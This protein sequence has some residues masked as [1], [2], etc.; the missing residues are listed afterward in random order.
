MQG[1]RINRRYFLMSAA[2]TTLGS[3]LVA[4]GGPSSSSS[5]V[6][7][8][9]WDYWVT[10]APWVDN[11]IK[12]FQQK[13]PSIKIKKTT[14]VTDQYPNLFDLAIKSNK[15]P[16]VFMLA[17]TPKINDQVAR[18]WLMPL[19][20]WAT[21]EWRSKF[22]QG[23]FFEGN[24]I[25]NGK[26]YSA[27][28]VG[29]A[30]WIQ[31]Y[32]NNAVFKAAGITNPD[33]SVKIPQ[34]WDDISRAADAI[35]KKGDNDVFPFGFGNGQAFI[36]PW[37]LEMFVRGAGAVGGAYDKDLRTGKY[38][39]G[40][41]RAYTDF[42]ELLL[43][44]KK[45]NYFYPN[46]MSISDEQARALFER[47]KF[48]MTVGGVW[49]QPEW[50]QHK[51]TDFSLMTLPT[52]DEKPKGYFY[53]GIGGTLWGM[54]AKTKHADE[55][56]AWMD[57]LYSKEAGKRWVEMGE[58]LSVYPENNDPANVKDKQFAQYVATA[59]LSLLAPIPEVRN[60]AVSQVIQNSVK[61]DISDVMTGIYT[62]QIGDVKAA[63]S[64]LAARMQ[65]SLDDGIKQAQQKGHKVGAA[66]YAFPDWDP[67][68]G[69]DYI[70]K[71]AS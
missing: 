58:D 22:P 66:D 56:W 40:T 38:T 7:L 16:D 10:Q 33:G 39:F 3:A 45:K 43:E 17:S 4:C 62:G 53:H 31:F 23:S 9:F 35:K 57:W 68:A 54:S 8:N 60:P 48:G 70:T 13:H 47:G 26:L 67:A 27:P 1:S 46:S 21:E 5:T 41:D 18:G 37:W 52:P 55:A 34:T 69:K 14:N 42:I 15:Q 2:A 20:K 63:L 64:E 12:L 44:W 50:K 19:D 29:S 51:F 25:F 24:N 65:K 11:E 32:I 36:L 71:P 6:T 49:N 61:P 59:K 28:L 30:P